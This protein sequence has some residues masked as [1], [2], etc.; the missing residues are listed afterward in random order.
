[1]KKLII[2]LI[3]ILIIILIVLIGGGI[4]AYVKLKPFLASSSAVNTNQEV[5]NTNQTPIDKNPLL[6][7]SQETTLEQIG[8]D[9][10]KLP[11]T[12]TPAMEA[13]F[14]EKLG[15]DRVNAIK[16]G[17]SPTTIDLFKVQSC[18]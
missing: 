6:T 1:M 13:C 18:L 3:I 12:I 5:T 17:A 4:Y 2:T 8:I 11:T 14:I 15:L 16:A 7:P 9:P 10:A